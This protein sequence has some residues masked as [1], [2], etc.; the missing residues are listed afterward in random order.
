MNL[1]EEVPSGLILRLGFRIFHSME[2]KTQR[3]DEKAFKHFGQDLFLDVVI[4]C[5]MC[6]H[7]SRAGQVEQ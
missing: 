7:L 4:P 6:H 3:E 1:N 5:I 2:R